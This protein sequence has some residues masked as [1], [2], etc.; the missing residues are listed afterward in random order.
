KAFGHFSKIE[1]I[2]AWFLAS[3]S[4]I[5]H[6]AANNHYHFSGANA[7]TKQG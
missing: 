7:G 1:T 5:K 6:A 2:I 4:C 3:T